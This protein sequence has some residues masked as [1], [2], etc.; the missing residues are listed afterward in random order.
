MTPFTHITVDAHI[1]AHQS[2]IGASLQQARAHPGTLH[3]L[4]GHVARGLVRTGAWLLPESP[5]VIGGTVFAL[6]DTPTS[7]LDRKAA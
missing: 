7:D 2:Q 6:P 5:E 3:A 4:R 1:G